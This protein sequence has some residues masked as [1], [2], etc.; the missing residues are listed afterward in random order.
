MRAFASRAV[1]IGTA[2]FA[3]TAA[4]AM[5]VTAA[6]GG[7]GDY[8][9]ANSDNRQGYVSYDSSQNPAITQHQD[10]GTAYTFS[11]SAT[12]GVIA[13]QA[14]GTSPNVFGSVT[15]NTND[16]TLHAKGLSNMPSSGG[17]TG[18]GHSQITDLI[19]FHNT[20]ASDQTVTVS[21]SLDG[22]LSPENNGAT[23]TLATVDAKLYLTAHGTVSGPAY[24]GNGVEYTRYDGINY[25]S[26]GWSKLYGTGSTTSYTDS[27]TG[28]TATM[29][30]TLAPG[31]TAFD[32]TDSLNVGGNNAIADYS[33]TSAITFG[34]SDP[35]HVSY[36]STGVAIPVTPEPT[37][38]TTASLATLLLAKR[39]RRGA[40][41]AV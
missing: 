41:D 26:N 27:G 30:I 7:N 1:W 29:A 39:R 5:T 4:R 16:A 28:G 10:P 9:A 19:T 3:S 36:T 11:S 33:N 15:V 38:L 24:Q 6:A 21:Y 18:Y 40:T 17:T 37:A 14:T 23:S 31:D 34:F 25:P 20:S 12:G 8:D 35:A 13:L 22:T 32:L 2:F